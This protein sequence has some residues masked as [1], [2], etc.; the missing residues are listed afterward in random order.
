[1][2]QVFLNKDRI[3]FSQ[4]CENASF[5]VKANVLRNNFEKNVASNVELS[6]QLE[7]GVSTMIELQRTAIRYTYN[8]YLQ[9]LVKMIYN[10]SPIQ[11]LR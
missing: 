4:A 9:I 11:I 5:N 7:I 8:K 6:L 10:I 2:I 1:M 3:V